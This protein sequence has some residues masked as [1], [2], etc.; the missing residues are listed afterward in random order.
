MEVKLPITSSSAVAI[1]ETPDNFMVEDR[2]NLPG[3]LAYPGRLQLFGGH[4]EPGEIPT[5]TIAR[6]LLEELG[7]VASQA[8]DRIWGGVVTSEGLLGSV[9]NRHV[10]LFRI[11]IASE[12][13]L[14][15]PED[16][17]VKTLPK[18]I[19]AIE[20]SSEK[21]TGFAY[22]ALRKVLNDEPWLDSYIDLSRS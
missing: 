8:P 15:I 5:Q 19:E 3:K 12:E 14:L 6:E 11:P 2:P 16:T 7:Y 9:V 10:T 18:T 22:E 20:D 4:A 1:I 13:E 17:K 21:L